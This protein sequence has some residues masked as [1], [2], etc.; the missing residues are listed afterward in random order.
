MCNNIPKP[1][2]PCGLSSGEVKWFLDQL[3][4]AHRLDKFKIPKDGSGSLNVFLQNPMAT[5]E[6]VRSLNRESFTDLWNQVL[7]GY[8]IILIEEPS[9]ADK[10]FIRELALFYGNLHNEGQRRD[11]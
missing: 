1:P 11:N 8:E 7:P 10:E 6:A 5:T 4:N 2:P 9:Q 3:A